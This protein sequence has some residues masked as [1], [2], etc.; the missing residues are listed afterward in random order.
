M[1]SKIKKIAILT[2]GG[3]APGMNSAIF[4]IVRAALKSGLEVF[5]VYDGYKGLIE[6]RIFPMTY[7]DVEGI[8]NK[9]GTILG[10]A[11]LPEFKEESVRK[12]AVK[13]LESHG[14]DAIV[15]I[16]GDGTY[17]GGLRLSELGIK[18]VGVPAT[19]DNDIPS[20][21]YTIGFDTCLNTIVEA[22]DK[23]RETANSHHRAIVVEVMGRYCPDLAIR[24]ALSCEAE[25]VIS[26][27]EEYNEQ[28]MLDALKVSNMN[29]K[30]DA[31][32]IVPEYTIP[33]EEINRV[34][35]EKTDLD[36]RFVVLGHM[37]RGGRPSA[38]DRVLAARLGIFAVELLM[39]GETGKCVGVIG[40]KLQVTDIIKANELPKKQAQEVK[41]CVRKI[42]M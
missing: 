38:F 5:G 29:G 34:I 4:A 8:A 23:M 40:D 16:G 33:V 31:I 20:T 3:D 24:S 26:S 19:I 14:I 25:Y 10:S 27:K 36:P 12:E 11:R 41:P 6:D 42:L 7:K 21:E 37:Q 15:C 39:K 1:E 2:S 32:V 13:I 18:C 35:K 28:E 9:G 22:I 17:M 30:K